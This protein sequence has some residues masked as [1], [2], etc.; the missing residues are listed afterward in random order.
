[1]VILRVEKALRAGEHVFFVDVD[2]AE[3][4][5]LRQVMAAHPSLRPA[6]TGCQG[7]V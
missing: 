2:P 4:D 5:T 3:E 7:G 6:G 1:M